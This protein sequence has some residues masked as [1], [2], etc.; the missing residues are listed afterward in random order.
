MTTKEQTLIKKLCPAV[1]SKNLIK[2]W[3][4]DEDSEK[5]GW[6]TVEPHL[7]GTHKTSKN[8]LLRAWFIP[9]SQQ[10]LE[11]WI[12]EWKLYK[13]WNITKEEILATKYVK[14]RPGY[15]PNDLMMNP[16][17]CKTEVVQ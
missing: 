9:N 5:V 11:G 3:Y 13:L 15:N 1:I 4:E 2:F 10:K 12:E 16:I 8:V 17:H 7:I 14:T 6:R